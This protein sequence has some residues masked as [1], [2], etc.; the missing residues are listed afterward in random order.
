VA[1][2]LPVA[3]IEDA[4]AA[5]SRADGRLSAVREFR[6][7]DVY[8]PK[9][10]SSKVAEASANALLNKEKSLAFRIVLQDTER[11]LND[12]DADAALAA[13]VEGL[14]KQCGARL[15]R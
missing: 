14:E 3:A 5:M 1:D 15:R 10:D 7:F 9:A 12:D 4:V 8:R 2:A 13:I 11:A 6:L